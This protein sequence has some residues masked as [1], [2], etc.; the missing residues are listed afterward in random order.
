MTLRR[1]PSQWQHPYDRMSE[2]ERQQEQ[3]DLDEWREHSEPSP[4]WFLPADA[5]PA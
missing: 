4:S 3:R 1:D 5:E 2:Q